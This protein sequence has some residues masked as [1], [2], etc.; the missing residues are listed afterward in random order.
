MQG[1]FHEF[2]FQQSC[3]SSIYVSLD[4]S[5]FSVFFAEVTGIF[6]IV[7]LIAMS[8]IKVPHYA[9][10]LCDCCVGIAGFYQNSA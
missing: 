7:L 2:V 6:V 8:S 1:I 9:I 5:F 10:L 4:F 3:F